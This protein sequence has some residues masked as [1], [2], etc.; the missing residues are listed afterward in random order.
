VALDQA[1][2]RFRNDDGS[3]SGASWKAAENTNV[4]IEEGQVFRIRYVITTN[5]G[6]LSDQICQHQYNLNGAGWLAAASR[7]LR[8]SS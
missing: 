2:Y 4:F 5:T 3:E 8:R 6:P 7:E 1:Y